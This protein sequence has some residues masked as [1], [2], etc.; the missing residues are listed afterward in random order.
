MPYMDLRLHTF[1][2]MVRAALLLGV[3]AGL[4]GCGEERPTPATTHLEQEWEVTYYHEETDS[5]EVRRCTPLQSKRVHPNMKQA[6]GSVSL[7]LPDVGLQ[8]EWPCDSLEVT[9]FAA[10]PGTLFASTA[11]VLCR[12]SPTRRL[13]GHLDFNAR[14]RATSGTLRFD[15]DETQAHVVLDTVRF[16]VAAQAPMACAEGVSGGFA[17]SA[18]AASSDVALGLTV[19]YRE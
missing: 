13:E 6:Q 15:D 3:V 11:Q 14:G 17:T 5:I 1:A 19:S 4:W 9:T 7:H 8:G 10:H 2:D 16:G 18:S 12:L